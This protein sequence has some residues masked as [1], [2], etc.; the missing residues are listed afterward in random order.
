MTTGT[1]K[2]IRNVCIVID[3]KSRSFF[4]PTLVLIKVVYVA[5]NLKSYGFYCSHRNLNSACWAFDNTRYQ[6]CEKFTSTC[7]LNVPLGYHHIENVHIGWKYKQYSKHLGQSISKCIWLRCHIELSE[8]QTN[9]NIFP[10]M[11][12][13]V[14]N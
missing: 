6:H 11:I 9:L 2:S 14:D 10:K 7:N 3:S 1:N 8:H 4:H 13:Q 12:R 5:D